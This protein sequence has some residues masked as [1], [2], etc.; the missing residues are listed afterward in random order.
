MRAITVWAKKESDSTWLEIVPLQGESFNLSKKLIDLEE[1]DMMRCDAS[2]TLYFPAENSLNNSFFS[3]FANFNTAHTFNPFD[4]YECKVLTATGSQLLIGTLYFIDY[5]QRKKLYMCQIASKIGTIKQRLGDRALDVMSQYNHEYSWTNIKSSWN[6]NTGWQS[7]IKYMPIDN[8]VGIGDVV[9]I[10]SVASPVSLMFY[11]SVN[12]KATIANIFTYLGFSFT[13]FTGS[14]SD[15]YMAIGGTNSMKSTDESSI[16]TN[17]GFITHDYDEWRIIPTTALSGKITVV[18]NKFKVSKTGAYS[19]SIN[20]YFKPGTLLFGNS[21]NVK[22][23]LYQG[24]TRIDSTDLLVL[25]VSNSNNYLIDTIGG[26]LTAGVE[27]EIRVFTNSNSIASII[28]S[29]DIVLNTPIS[30]TEYLKRVKLYDMLQMYRRL[31]DVYFVYNQ[32]EN[33]FEAH[34]Y[35]SLISAGASVDWTNKIEY[36]TEF[37]SGSLINFIAA[38]YNYLVK[39]SKNLIDTLTFNKDGISLGSFQLFLPINSQQSEQKIELI[40][41]TWVNSDDAVYRFYKNYDQKG[42]PKQN[43]IPLVIAYFDT[44][45]TVPTYKLLNESGAEVT[46]DKIGQFENVKGGLILAFNRI[47]Q[48]IN[49]NDNSSSVSLYKQFHHP[50][51]AEW[52]GLEFTDGV[53]A[54]LNTSDLANARILPIQVWLSQSEFSAITLG[55]EVYINTPLGAEYFRILEISNYNATGNSPCNVKL[56]RIL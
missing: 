37:K 44:E 4:F 15:V 5:D 23:G 48:Y 2:K 27:Y 24:E 30:I 33:R 35:S 26:T 53:G 51:F 49:N 39:Q 12:I 14:P 19:I 34:T 20:Q 55:E 10:A 13:D 7:L 31:Y 1:I 50:K 28:T 17:G 38:K 47:D 41:S 32:T 22:I 45:A 56:I 3:N 25:T 21:I 54:T 43:D 9:N 40:T 11:P 18:D 6:T 8:G 29:G 16:R 42:D 36:K 52:I 46:Y